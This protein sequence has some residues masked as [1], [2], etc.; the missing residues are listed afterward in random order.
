MDIVKL[1]RQ[2]ESMKVETMLE[3][4]HE[5]SLMEG[6]NEYCLRSNLIAHGI[7]QWLQ[8]VS[9]FNFSPCLCNEKGETALNFSIYLCNKKGGEGRW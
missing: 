5:L 3:G 4:E 6:H 7:K 1:E 2:F 8:V 9:T